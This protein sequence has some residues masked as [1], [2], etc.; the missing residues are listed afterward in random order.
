MVG[1]GYEGRRGGGIVDIILG[2]EAFDCKFICIV[3]MYIVVQCYSADHPLLTP[4]DTHFVECGTFLYD[5][6][7]PILWIDYFPQRC[8]RFQD[9]QTPHNGDPGLSSTSAEAR[10]NCTVCR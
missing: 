3:H 6:I 10:S 5:Y 9:I 7:L 4:I 2:V 8:R 1:V